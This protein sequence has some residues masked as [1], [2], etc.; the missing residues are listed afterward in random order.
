MFST[1]MGTGVTGLHSGVF[2]SLGQPDLGRHQLLGCRPPQSLAVYANRSKSI[3]ERGESSSDSSLFSSMQP[4]AW[5]DQ[6][7]KGLSSEDFQRTLIGDEVRFC[8]GDG[9][10]SSSTPLF[11]VGYSGHNRGVIQ[12]G[13]SS[14]VFHRILIGDEVHVCLGVIQNG[15]VWENLFGEEGDKNV[16]TGLDCHLDL[17]ATDDEREGGNR[18]ITDSNCNWS[19]SFLEESDLSEPLNC[20]PV[21]ILEPEASM[22][23]FQNLIDDRF[24][25]ENGNSSDCEV[26]EWVQSRVKGLSKL[27]GVSYEGFEDEILNLFSRIESKRRDRGVF[28]SRRKVVSPGSRRRE[29]RKLEW[30]INYEV[31]E[32]NYAEVEG[33]ESNGCTLDLVA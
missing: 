17:V 2:K 30:T 27:L 11:S 20:M 18:C 3:N 14:E 23:D 1:K 7:P 31:G 21:A 25:L 12:N 9:F 32:R 13:N 4:V 24:L 22:A 29:L 33:G 10:H 16:D 6:D 8:L 19:S 26:S 5:L 28:S 15:A